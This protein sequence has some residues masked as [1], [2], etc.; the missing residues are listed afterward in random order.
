MKILFTR[1][2]LE[3][4]Y[5]GAEVQTMS[6]IKG[7]LAKRH[8]IAFL[9]SCPVL[10]EKCSEEGILCAKLKIGPPPVSTWGALSFLWRKQHMQRLLE[11]ALDQ[12]QRL[13]AICMLSL[14]EKILLTPIALAKG[15]PVVWIEHD[16][17]GNWLRRNPWLSILQK[18]SNDVTTVVVS[19]LSK[20]LYTEL[21]WDPDKVIAIP[22]GIDLERF[23]GSQKAT[24]KDGLH[25][26]TVARLTQ[27]KGVDVLIT[28]ISDIPEAS[29][30]IV[31]Q[32]REKGF[33]RKLADQANQPTSQRVK[34]L[35]SVA[36]LGSFYTS[37]DMF[38]LPS[39][40]HDPFGLVAAEAM[41]LGIPIIVTDACGIAGYL[42]QD[43]DALIVPANDAKA[44]RDA[45]KKLQDPVRRISIGNA[46]R[47]TAQHQFALHIMIDKYE[48]LFLEIQ[49]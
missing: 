8:A 15:I 49:V 43:L 32:G 11:N 35:P 1:F 29:L 30:T 20:K 34:L 39:R 44:L 26:G 24:T 5:G 3:S 12:F 23:T 48:K 27:D 18:L 37:L 22:N 31:G 38:V 21:G 6:L 47:K 16:R 28:A 45:V 41:S 40:E 2:P 33:L 9:G 4:A 19:D 7:L 17:V 13:D 14:S 36:D 42:M 46:A 10:L 25:I